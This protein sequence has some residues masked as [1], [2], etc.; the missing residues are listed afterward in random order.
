MRLTDMVIL[1][2]IVGMLSV[3]GMN[4]FNTIRKCENEIIACR[5]KTSADY[6]IAESFRKTCRGEGFENLNK[7][8]VICRAMWNLEYIG[9]CDASDFMIVDYSIN[10]RK[11]MYGKWD[12]SDSSGEVYCR[13]Y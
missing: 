6:F 4:C 1:L 13:R 3:T 5:R 11:L 2:F 12:G 10:D 7:W 8:Q 9:W